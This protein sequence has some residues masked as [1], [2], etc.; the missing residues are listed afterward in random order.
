M[1]SSF[2]AAPPTQP[3]RAARR[4]AAGA[5]RLVRTAPERVDPPALDAAQRAVVDHRHGPLLVL[6]GPG[7]GKTTTLV[8]SVVRRVR[9]GDDPE[10]ILVLTFSRKAAVELRDRLAARLSGPDAPPA[11]PA[12]PGGGPRRPGIPQATTFH[13]FCYALVRA[14]QDA[15]LFADPLRLLSG[16]EQDLVVRELLEGQAELAGAGR[17]GC[18]GRTSCGPA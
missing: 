6:A 10:R 8:E 5:Y 2:S 17:A 9:A 3:H 4:D 11:G 18:A 7:T 15:E 13:S 16:P 1:S 14:H 12:V